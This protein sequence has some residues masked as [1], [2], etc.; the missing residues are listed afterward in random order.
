MD[1]L[2]C[3]KIQF[4]IHQS[5]KNRP[6]P[7]RPSIGAPTPMCFAMAPGSGGPAV[8]FIGF[9]NAIFIVFIFRTRQNNKAAVHLLSVCVSL[10]VCV[11]VCLCVCVCASLG[12]REQLIADCLLYKLGWL[13]QLAVRACVFPPSPIQYKCVIGLSFKFGWLSQL[14]VMSP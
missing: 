7:R 5:K 4:S 12:R 9:S 2:I 6:L 3:K 1:F 8:R 14:A 13:L 11:S 10:C